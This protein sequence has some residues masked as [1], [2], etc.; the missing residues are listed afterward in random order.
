MNKVLD[1]IE[2]AGGQCYFVGGCVRDELLGI[3]CKDI[4]VEV[5]NLDSESLI[6]VLK[7]FGK[8]DIVG[9]SFGVIKLTA[10]GQEY[11]FTLPRR[12]N[13]TGNKHDDFEIVVDHTMTPKEAAM[14]RDFTINAISKRYTTG[15]IV[16]PFGGQTDLN[17]KM[18]EPTSEFFAEDPLRI[19]RGVQFCGRFELIATAN[20]AKVCR[21]VVTQVRYLSQER[22][23]EEFDK[24][25]L[26]SVKP[27]MGLQFMKDTHL[28]SLYPELRALIDCPQDPEYHPE[29]CT[30]V[31][32]KHVC[33]QAVEIAVR[34]GLSEEDRRVLVLAALAHDLGKA[35]CTEIGD[36]G[37]IVSPRHASAGV[38]LTKTLLTRM[39]YS[40]TIIEPVQ[41]LVK[42]HMDHL[43]FKV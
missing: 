38:D 33:D 8:V 43:G 37:R 9:V 3:P 22:I 19:L 39:G 40:D 23:R 10:N 35:E 42:Y 26:K 4:D 36:D 18:L 11:D 15:E 13:K 41:K 16:D 12:D 6:Q 24:F 2:N 7:R 14:R 20:C 21:E 27:S 25:L 1:A 34:E 30:F 29:I 31:H 17:R 32:T 28:I 5:Y